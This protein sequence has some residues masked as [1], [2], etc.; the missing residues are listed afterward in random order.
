RRVP[1]RNILAEA[2]KR[3]TSGCLVWAAANAIARYG[4][5]EVTM[6]VLTADHRI[7]EH[8]LFRRTIDAAMTA[9]EHYS[10]LVTIGV[11]PVRPDTGYGYIEIDQPQPV[12]PGF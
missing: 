1:S 7:G 3:N 8:D 4:H 12:L 9:A 2:C 10:S 5:E 6:A 11:P